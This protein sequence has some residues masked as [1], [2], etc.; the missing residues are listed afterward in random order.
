MDKDDIDSYQIEYVVGGTHWP[1]YVP[2]EREAVI[3]DYH[4]QN[5]F[6]VSHPLVDIVAHPWW[7]HGYWQDSDGNYRTD[8]WFD[9]FGKIPKAIHNEFASAAIQHDKVVEIN[10]SA[11]LLNPHYP[12]RFKRAILGIYSGIEISRSEALYWFR[13]P[14]FHL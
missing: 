6:L 14:F 3:Y 12:E 8:P 1:M 5:M 2:I 4:R 13:L 7:W 10:I 11:I 9:D